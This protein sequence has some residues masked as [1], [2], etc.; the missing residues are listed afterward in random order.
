MVSLC[1]S[2]RITASALP[3]S[4]GIIA[5]VDVTS[6]SAGLQLV[7]GHAWGDTKYPFYKTFFL[8]KF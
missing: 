7:N 4:D 1:A 2:L 6:D 8:K 5:H 3:S